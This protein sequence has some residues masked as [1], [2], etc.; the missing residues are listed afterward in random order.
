MSFEV[1]MRVRFRSRLSIGSA[2]GWAAASISMSCPHRCNRKGACGCRHLLTIV[3]C[4]RMSCHSV[5]V[6]ALRT[7]IAQLSGKMLPVHIPSCQKQMQNDAMIQS[8]Q[9]SSQHE[10]SIRVGR[11]GWAKEGRKQ[12]F[13]YKEN[14]AAFQLNRVHC[15]S[16]GN[17]MAAIGLH[18]TLRAYSIHGHYF[19]LEN[20]HSC[21]QRVHGSLLNPTRMQLAE[22][23]FQLPCSYLHALCS[24]CN[25]GAGLRHSLACTVHMPHACPA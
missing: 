10:S 3:F 2:I 12:S 17:A 14:S 19:K 18:S 4:V 13:A 1:F 21:L 5:N 16:E 15:I 23:T 25:D 6:C 22:G 8:M 24:L 7:T 20:R 9:C 11:S